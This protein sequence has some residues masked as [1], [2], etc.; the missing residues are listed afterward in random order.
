M[1]TIM[2]A[3]GWIGEFA[4]RV[5]RVETLS[6]PHV[7]AVPPLVFSA[8]PVGLFVG[9]FSY[10]RHQRQRASAFASSNERP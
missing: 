4:L 1:L 7:L 5:V 3:F 6:I 9:T 10:V 2:W 8:F